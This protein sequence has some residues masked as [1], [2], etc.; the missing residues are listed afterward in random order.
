[1]KNDLFDLSEVPTALGTGL[2]ALDVVI[3]TDHKSRPHL[4]A[5]GTCGNVLTIL[6]YLGWQSY[7][8]ARLS[9]DAA[10]KVVI[11][12]FKKWG[13]K[14]DFAHLHPL[15]D[16]PIVIERIK[17]LQSGHVIH[18]FSWTCPNCGAWLPGYKPVLA[19]SIRNITPKLGTPKVFFFDR[20]SRGAIELAKACANL[21]AVIVF[22]P[23]GMGDPSLF[24]EALDYVHILKYSNER[25]NE[26]S[27]KETVSGPFLIIET[28]GADGLRYR[29]ELPRCKSAS[30][31]TATS[32]KVGELKDAA[33]AGDWCTAG[34]LHVIASHG[35]EGLQNVT[36]EDLQRAISFGQ[37][38]AAWN[39]QYEGA[40]GGMYHVDAQ[41]FRAEVSRILFGQTIN[42][43][44]HKLA[45]EKN[46]V[47]LKCMA[48]GCSHKKKVRKEAN[49]KMSRT[50][51]KVI[52][53]VINATNGRK[54]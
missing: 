48:P 29:S 47:V 3:N 19:T 4:Y 54:R 44:I 25:M 50:T 42:M 2:I 12:D 1:M 31:Q 20:L 30:W 7:P 15:S 35:L 24:A 43:T 39:C 17:R 45:S 9:S 34:I 46:G 23:S 18:R 32:C 22:E 14:M 26:M 8:V 52:H 37:A 33:G 11:N 6:S 51:N 41:T 13:I 10:A 21:G 38:M 5:G 16:T 27:G 49:K 36:K 28:L 40:R 53:S